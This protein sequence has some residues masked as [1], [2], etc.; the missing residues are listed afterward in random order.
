M[1]VGDIL[2]IFGGTGGGIGLVMLAL[3]ITG[4]IVPGSRIQDIE[5]EKEELKAERNEWKKIS[6]IERQRADVERQRADAGIL[7]GQIV[8]DIMLSLRKEIQL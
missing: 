8:K 6:E 7:A 1:S 2:S 5:K 3:F 4:H